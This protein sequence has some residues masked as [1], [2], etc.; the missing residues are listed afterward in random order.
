[1]LGMCDCHAVSSATCR[2][3]TA[4]GLT[5]Y[6]S[7][8]ICGDASAVEAMDFLLDDEARISWWVTNTQKICEHKIGKWTCVESRKNQEAVYVVCLQH[9]NQQL[10]HTFL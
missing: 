1:M 2:R 5:E 10:S 6:L 9:A 4:A 8:T 7:V 3:P